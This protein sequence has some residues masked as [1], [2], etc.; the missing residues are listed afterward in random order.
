MVFGLL[1]MVASVS[2]ARRRN[3]SCCCSQEVWPTISL[4]GRTG[5]MVVKQGIDAT[6]AR[7]GW[8]PMRTHEGRVRHVPDASSHRRGSTRHRVLSRPPPPPGSSRPAALLLISPFILD[9][10][11]NSPK[12]RQSIAVL[13]HARAKGT[14]HRRRAYSIAPGERLSPS[15]KARRLLVS[16]VSLQIHKMCTALRCMRRVG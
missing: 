10:G 14:T 2:L 15:Q 13:G 4:M 11:K 7:L 12:R 16:C 9:M 8:L 5:E 6:V 3:K 1:V